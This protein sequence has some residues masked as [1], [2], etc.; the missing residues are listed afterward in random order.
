MTKAVTVSQLNSYINRVLST[1]PILMNVSVCGEIANLTKH[2]SGHWYFSLKDKTSNIKCF[3]AS[4]RV[5]KLPFDLDEG[6]EII[7]FG[8]VSVYEK[9]GYYSLNVKDIE[10][11]GEGA[12]Q[13]AFEKLKS[14]LEEEGLFDESRKREIPSFPQRVGV[15]TSPTGA[16]IKDIITTIKRRNPLVDV[17]LFP[18]LV[19]GFGSAESVC[20]AIECMNTSF[21]DTDVL[22]V[23]R[24]G[25]SM[26][27]LWTFNEESVARAIFASRIPVI[28]AVGHETDTTISDFVADLR[29]ATPTA[30]AELSVPNIANYID[31]I[32]SCNPIRMYDGLK[33]RIEMAVIRLN[34]L[35][36]Q[37]KTLINSNISQKEQ[38]IKLLM[39][40]IEALNPLSV[41]DKGYAAI[42]D[43]DGIWISDI[44]C[45]NA[46]DKL[47]VVLKN[48]ILNV[49]V[50]SKEE[51]Y[52]N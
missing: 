45:V 44:S 13:K 35:H 16:A 9:G 12:L 24:G 47:K 27:D 3:L 6:M 4:S 19:Q 8:N 10:P 20:S 15:I 50:D 52:G 7:A 14:K 37:I 40:D 31:R 2:S 28:S 5:I 17:L 30:G 11:Q 51:N 46:N 29:A 38:E 43:S 21:P 33:S 48:G 36:Q 49:T 23:G 26:E 42:K 32:E 22:I 1:D 25:G 41:L 39:A 34:S 18:A